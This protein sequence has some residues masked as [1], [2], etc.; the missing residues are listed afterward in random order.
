MSATVKT[1]ADHLQSLRDN[2]TIFIDG[3][4][5]DDVTG[6]PAFRHAVRSAAALYDYQA[7]PAYLEWMT[8][9]SP[10]QPATPA[11]R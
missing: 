8:F 4:R 7:D 10:S 5:V 3:E 9:A 6:H 2:R 11:F 1:G